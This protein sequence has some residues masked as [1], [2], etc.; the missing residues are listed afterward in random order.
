MPPD[1]LPSVRVLAGLSVTAL[2]LAAFL[3]VAV[4]MPAETGRDPSGL[5]RV[6]GLAEMGRIKVALA[7][8]AAADVDVERVERA[9]TTRATTAAGA[10]RWRDSITVTLQPTQGIEFKLS[11]RTSEKAFFEWTTEGGEVYFNM[12]GEP[13]NAPKDY[14]A[15]RYGKGTSSAESGELV[16]AFDGVH[17]W[18]W[19][20]R[21][22]QPVAITLKT[23]G[24]Y[25]V[26]EEM[27]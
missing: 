19:R 8:E 17:G 5:G 23:G 18:F 26:L 13:L 9:A 25:L 27:K 16:A 3:A 6:L 15:H 21:T 7:K 1:N 4:V 24:A 20:N 11:M 22:D 12:H 10:S 2:M 14:A